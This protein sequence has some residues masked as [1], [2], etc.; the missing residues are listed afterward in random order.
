METTTTENTEAKKE[1]LKMDLRNIFST[2]LCNAIRAKYGTWADSLRKVDYSQ[3]YS[4]TSGFDTAP[5][6]L[7]FGK[8]KVNGQDEILFLG[9]CTP[10]FSLEKWAESSVRQDTFKEMGVTEIFTEKMTFN[11]W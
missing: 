9:H 10:W 5:I 11:S 7:V 1:D 6:T 3:G 8:R 2:D 4:A